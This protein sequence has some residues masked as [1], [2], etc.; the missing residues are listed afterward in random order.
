M[1]TW[2]IAICFLTFLAS[3][4]LAQT[5]VAVTIDTKANR[6]PISP[7]IY[8]VG[9]GSN[10]SQ[11]LHIASR[12]LGGDRMCTYNWENNASNSG[13]ISDGINLWLND[14]YLG[15]TNT[16][17]QLITDFH[18]GSKSMSCYSLVTLQAM[19]YVAKDKNGVVSAAESAPSNRWAKVIFDGGSVAPKSPDLADGNVYIDE[20]LNLL[21]GKYGAA[22]AGGINAYGF[23]N[24]PGLWLYAFSRACP[25]RKVYP[26][27]DESVQLHTELAKV[28]KRVDPSAE[29]FGGT[30]YGYSEYENLNGDDDGYNAHGFY[31]DYLLKQMKAASDIAGIR[32]MDALDLHWYPEA[33]GKDDAGNDVRIVYDGD[34]A[35]HENDRGVAEARMQA[36]RSLWDNTYDEKSWI[37][38]DH[39]QG[40]LDLLHLIQTKINTNNPGT[41]LAIG[42]YD[43]GGQDHISGGIATADVL[44]IFADQD[45]YLAN[46]WE[47]PRSYA[48]SAMKLYRNFDGANASFG[49]ISVSSSTENQSVSSIHA[50]VES[51]PSETLH[52]IALNKS[53]DQ[54]LAMTFA[55]A[56]DVHYDHATIYG[57]DQSGTN[58]KHIG[59]IKNIGG[60]SF[61]W[62]VPALTA[63]HIIVEPANTFVNST[64][65]GHSKLLAFQHAENISLVMESLARQAELSVYDALGKRILIRELPAGT[66]TTSIETNLLRSGLYFA[67]I[68]NGKEILTTSF[69]SY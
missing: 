57:F 13:G 34:H 29:F 25:N 69:L 66:T 18:D 58:I 55:I 47:D 40:P 38:K 22:S 4:A 67:R 51:S 59:T 64:Q 49:D 23:D 5:P 46:Y 7:L 24:E 16:P 39:T 68:T 63:L 65:P 6:H 50:S 17:A 26:T 44:G 15:N 2:K 54:S 43:Y 53:Y 41:K 56:S 8:G 11:G 45:I 1:K 30:M 14:D 48:A 21:K 27:Y 32:L 35:D 10:T 31:V 9:N 37:T 33:T 36:P 12:R 61:V 28:I 3:E 19:G 42:E 52:L 60:N 20:E 62:N